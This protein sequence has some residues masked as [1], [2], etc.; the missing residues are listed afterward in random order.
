MWPMATIL[1]SADTEHFRHPRKLYWATLAY[2]L[3]SLKNQEDGD[4]PGGPAVKNPPANAGK[5]GLISGLGRFHMLWG[6]WDRVPRLLS[7]QAAS[8]EPVRPV[9]LC[10]A[11]REATVMRNPCAEAREW[12]PLLAAAR[13]K[14][15]HSS[16]D[17]VKPKIN[18][19]KKIKMEQWKIIL[20]WIE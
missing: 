13:E 19:L 12:Q 2:T 16:E 3:V 6:N 4:F 15:R 18:K 5:L 1:D 11:T 9:S 20:Q 7:P 17:T 8:T 10:S 14:S